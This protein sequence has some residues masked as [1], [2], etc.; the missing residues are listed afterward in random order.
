VFY[1]V[2]YVGWSLE[3]NFSGLRAP[4]LVAELVTRAVGLKQ[5]IKESQVRYLCEWIRPRT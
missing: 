3:Q 1:A 2:L 4:R 5:K